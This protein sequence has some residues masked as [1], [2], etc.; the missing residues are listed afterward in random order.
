MGLQNSILD[1]MKTINLIRTGPRSGRQQVAQTSAT[2][3][4]TRK[5]V[6]GK[7]EKY[8]DERNLG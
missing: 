2:V 6:K 4:S 1:D 3:D 5:E 7:T 8:V